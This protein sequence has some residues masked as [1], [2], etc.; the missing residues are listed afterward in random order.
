MS[1]SV[2]APAI[3]VEN[4][5]LAFP[6]RGHGAPSVIF[7][8]FDL[9]V[10]RGEFVAVV[11]RSGVGKST[12]LRILA[13]LA[14]PSQGRFEI[15]VDARAAMRPT[16][17]VF[18]DSRLLPWRRIAANVALG[19]EGL[20]LARPERDRRALAALARVGLAA[21]A[22]KWPH[23]LSGGQRQRVALARALAVEPALLLM[24]EPFGALDAMTRE[25]LQDELLDIWERTKLTV[26]FVTHAVEEAILLANRVVVMTPGPGRIES[27]NGLELVRPRDVASP[28]FNAIRRVLSAKLHSHHGKKA[29]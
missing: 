23:Q 6:A 26:V 13:G 17:L 7:E 10:A 22:D 15:D 11:G 9:E 12:L 1:A 14:R 18:Q 8:N 29:A 27:D 19:L 16:G 25:R 4:L 5:G 21:H 24:D 20:G 2:P 3:V 28:E